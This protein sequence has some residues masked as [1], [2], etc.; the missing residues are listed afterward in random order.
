MRRRSV[1]LT[2]LSEPGPYP[3]TLDGSTLSLSDGKQFVATNAATGGN[4]TVSLSNNSTLQLIGSTTSY[5]GSGLN[6]GSGS[7]VEMLAR[8]CRCNALNLQQASASLNGYRDSDMSEP[9]E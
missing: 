3:A 1:L 5:T 4:N 7:R 6:V 9:D 8:H 2:N